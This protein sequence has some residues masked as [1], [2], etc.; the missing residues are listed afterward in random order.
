MLSKCRNISREIRVFQTLGGF[1]KSRKAVT[2]IV[3]FAW[4]IAMPVAPLR[5]GDILRGGASAANG[6]RASEA[7]ANAGA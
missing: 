2:L 3:L 6:R 4:I 5:A 1:Q 7:R